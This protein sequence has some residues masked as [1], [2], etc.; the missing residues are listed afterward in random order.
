MMVEIAGGVV[1]N[2]KRGIAVVNQNNN[3]WSLP[4][5]HKEAGEDDLSTAKR[6]IYEETGIPEESLTL[7]KKLGAYERDR[8]MRNPTDTPEPRTITLFLFTTGEEVLS[9]IDPM[10][11]S[12][13]WV[14]MK[15]VAGLLTHPKDKEYFDSIKNEIAVY[16]P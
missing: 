14:P 5:G 1:I 6:E 8:I 10:N 2:P 13:L 9:P 3:S 4:K 7:I 11:P 12:A 16:F 15:D